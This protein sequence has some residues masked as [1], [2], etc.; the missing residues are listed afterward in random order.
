MSLTKLKEKQKEL[1]DNFDERVAAVE[2]QLEPSFYKYR[3]IA[4]IMI[5]HNQLP[6]VPKEFKDDLEYRKDELALRIEYCRAKGFPEIFANDLQNISGRLGIGVDTAASL[7]KHAYPESQFKL[8]LSTDTEHIMKARASPND[9][10]Q[11]FK[12]TMVEAQK[13]HL[14]DKNNP[15][16]EGYS[17]R[18][19][20]LAKCNFK[21]SFYIM[22]RTVMNGMTIEEEGL[23]DDLVLPTV[24]LIKQAERTLLEN[25]EVMQT[26]FVIQPAAEPAI[27]PVEEVVEAVVEVLD[28]KVGDPKDPAKIEKEIVTEIVDP[29]ELRDELTHVEAVEHELESSLNSQP[30]S[31]EEIKQIRDDK[32]KELPPSPDAAPEQVEEVAEVAPEPIKENIKTKKPIESL[33]PDISF[34]NKKPE[35]VKPWE[36]NEL[37]VNDQ[38]LHTA[39]NY[40]RL[41]EDWFCSLKVDEVNDAQIRDQNIIAYGLVIDQVCPQLRDQIFQTFELLKA[42]PLN[43]SDRLTVLFHDAMVQCDPKPDIPFIDTIYFQKMAKLCFGIEVVAQ[44]MKNHHIT[45]SGA[46]FDHMKKASKNLWDAKDCAFALRY[47]HARNLL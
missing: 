29:K 6:Q 22:D 47:M 14:L 27:E 39:E 2:A 37:I 15:H 40:A 43:H 34:L 9:D 13:L 32:I 36:F 45:E 25:P 30:F 7:F 23:S 10:W 33:K 4:E 12:F 24:P 18:Q 26:S 42:E 28:P 41:G 1:H 11:D 44:D 19:K 46:Q 31:P 35:L 8:I 17:G 5:K 21:N 38:T 3:N 20:M 16:W